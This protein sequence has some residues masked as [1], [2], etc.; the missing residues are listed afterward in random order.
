[1]N[2]DY[3]SAAN[4]WIARAHGLLPRAAIAVS[5]FAATIQPIYAQDANELK[6]KLEALERQVQLLKGEIERLGKKTEEVN[7]K[8]EALATQQENAGTAPLPAGASVNAAAAGGLNIPGAAATVDPRIGQT[9][10]FG[11]GE[12]NYNRPRDTSQSKVTVRRAVLG[13]GHRFNDKLRL[14]SEFE[15]ENAV[16]SA[17]DGGEVEVEQLYLDYRHSNRLNIKAGLYLMPL[18]LLNESHEPTRYFGVERNDVER[19]II[20]TTWREV[21]VGTYGYF[22]NG[23]YYDVG[24]TS[25]FNLHKWDSAEG[26]GSPLLAIHQEGAQASAKSLATYGAIRY[27]GVP[28]LRL[29]AG[30]WSG[31]SSQGNGPFTAGNSRLDLSGISARIS[32]W[33]MHAVW[34]PGNWDLRALYAHGSIGQAGQI[35]DVLSSPAVGVTSGFVPK[36]FDGWYLQSA[37]K[38]WSQG[39]FTVKP[40]FRYERFN[41][42]RSLPQGYEG[43]A[44]PTLNERVLTVGVS[45]FV[46]P[47][48]VLKTDV[49]RYRADRNRDRFNLGLGYH[50]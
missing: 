28:G 32:L 27:L 18:G 4:E 5:L 19:R 21:G 35:N 20:P 39:D 43:F 44:D 46:T 40:F 29:G 16:T 30:V 7:A 6:S 2:N 37:Y 13:F 17:T 26:P 1:M 49:Q 10:V 25:S 36:S 11:Y 38:A 3:S 31:Q 8:T 9:S 23:I 33:D 34:T 22:D 47:N 12:I 41:T 24:I 42:Q 45:V 15:F 14:V 48:A 50:F